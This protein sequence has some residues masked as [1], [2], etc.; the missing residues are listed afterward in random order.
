MQIDKINSVT[1]HNIVFGN[2]KENEIK[3]PFIYKAFS[4]T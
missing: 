3:I 2:L 1:T 4:R